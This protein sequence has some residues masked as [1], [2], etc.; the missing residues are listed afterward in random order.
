MFRLIK[1]LFT[2][3]L[4]LTGSL[5]TKYKS[6]NNEPCMP[7]PTLIDFN[8]GKLIII[9]SWLVQ[10]NVVKSVIILLMTYLQKYVLRVK[11]K[12]K[13]LKYLTW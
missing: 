12:I 3:L 2:R 5:S 4:S 10:I 1:Q 13:M 7:R 6:L 11:L 8:L 9:Y